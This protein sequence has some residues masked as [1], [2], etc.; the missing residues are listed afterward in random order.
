MR[1]KRRATPQVKQSSD[2]VPA[3]RTKSPAKGLNRV[4]AKGRVYWYHRA[5]GKRLKN[6]PNTAAGLLEIQALDAKVAQAARERSDSLA[7]I[8]AEYQKDDAGRAGRIRPFRKLAERTQRDYQECID[9]LGDDASAIFPAD[10]KPRS[11]QKLV[12]D[13]AEVNGWA[14]GDKLL[15]FVRLLVNWGVYHELCAECEPCRGVL[16]PARDKNAEEANRPWSDSERVAMFSAA[17]PQFVILLGLCLYAQLN[18]AEAIRI[19]PAAIKR[20]R[21]EAGNITRRL[22]WRRGKNGEPIDVRISGPLE[23]IMDAAPKHGATLAL[24]ERGEPYTYSGADSVRKRLVAKLAKAGKVDL[25][26]TFHGL[27]HTLGAVAAEGGA[28]EKAIAAAIHDGTSA[29]GA[30]YS[31]GAERSRLAEEARKPLIE[32]DERLISGILEVRLQNQLQNSSKVVA[33][34]SG[35]A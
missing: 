2:S 25:G 13:A 35:K 21:D 16:A 3:R 28:S 22:K 29:M 14:F 30:L 18:I 1:P 19:P 5:T 26:L 8:I 32:R 15:S 34:R 9:Y 11:V 6:D 24:N 33:L 17:S 20:E 27:R 7:H 12:D 31:R 4:R 10:L 23:I